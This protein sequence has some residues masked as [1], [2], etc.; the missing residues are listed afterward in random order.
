[1]NDDLD[2]LEQKLATL[3]AHVDALRATN[4]VLRRDLAQANERNRALAQ[5]MQAASARLDA[6]LERLPAAE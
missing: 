4:E 3:I 2:S 5:R 1:M 6:V